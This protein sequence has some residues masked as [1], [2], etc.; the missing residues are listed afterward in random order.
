MFVITSSTIFSVNNMVFQRFC[1]QINFVQWLAI[2]Y[3][4]EPACSV[5][6]WFNLFFSLWQYTD[7]IT[8]QHFCI[9]NHLPCGNYTQMFFYLLIIKGPLLTIL[10]EIFYFNFLVN[11]LC[12]HYCYQIINTF[13]FNMTLLIIYFL[14]TVT[15]I[16]KY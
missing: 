4:V 14:D 5:C 3:S 2:A 13:H 15:K 10:N 7:R 16:A 6:L 8:I 9:G 12:I 1:I 11:I